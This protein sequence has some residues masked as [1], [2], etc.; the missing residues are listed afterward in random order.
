M[1]FFAPAPRRG[2]H[3]PR[4]RVPSAGS[5]LGNSVIIGVGRRKERSDWRRINSEFIKKIL[6][7]LG[8]GS[9]TFQLRPVLAGSCVPENVEK[10]TAAHR[11]YSIQTPGENV[12]EDDFFL[13][14]SPRS[15]HIR[16]FERDCL[17]AVAACCFDVF[18]DIHKKHA[19]LALL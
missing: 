13:D 1:D 2:W 16:S 19:P 4:K 15:V 14:S 10:E 11:L 12:G 17:R 7:M 18:C 6:K 3:E 9:L 5:I 8:N